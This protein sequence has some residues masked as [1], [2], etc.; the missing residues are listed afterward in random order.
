LKQIQLEEREQIKA[1]L[2]ANKETKKKE[3]AAAKQKGSKTNKKVDQKVKEK[4]DVEEEL[5]W[6]IKEC[7]DVV[8][9]E[10]PPTKGFKKKGRRA[11]LTRIRNARKCKGWK[12]ELLIEF[13]TGERQWSMFHGPLL[14]LQGPTAK[15]MKD[16]GLT[17]SICGYKIDPKKMTEKKRKEIISYDDFAHHNRTNYDILAQVIH[18][19]LRTKTY[20]D[21]DTDYEDEN[22]SDEE[23]KV[24][25]TIDA[26]NEYEDESKVDDTMNAETEDNIAETLETTDEDKKDNV[27]EDNESDESKTLERRMP[28]AFSDNMVELI[29]QAAERAAELALNDNDIPE[30]MEKTTDNGAQSTSTENNETAEAQAEAQPIDL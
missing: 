14:D 16:C 17:L 12:M 2:K 28:V 8:S 20:N 13:N 19:N 4:V 7:S 21:D 23:S 10:C 18:D 30:E 3:A 29:R 1:T 11:Y 26:E 6:E 24:D 15:F 25:D 5:I 22:E 27:G 9:D